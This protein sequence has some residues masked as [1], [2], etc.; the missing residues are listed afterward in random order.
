MI[1]AHFVGHMGYEGIITEGADHILGYRNANS[2][3]RPSACAAIEVAL[4][5]LSIE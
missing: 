5:K 2:V 1:W 3:Y 4:E